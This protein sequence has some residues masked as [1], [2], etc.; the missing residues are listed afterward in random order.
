MVGLAAESPWRSRGIVYGDLVR[1]VD[2]EE[3]A[4]PSLLLDRIRN[5]PEDAELELAIVRA[6]SEIT[7]RAPVSDRAHEMKRVSIPLIYS[8]SRERDLT[9]TSILLGLIRW[10]HTPAAWN[11][12]LLWFIDFGGGDANRLEPVER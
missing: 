2:G 12:R 7:I 9:T 8:F 5:S 3:V 1:A 6:G 11:V 10:E 4:D